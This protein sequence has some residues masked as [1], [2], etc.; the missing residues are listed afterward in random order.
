MSRILTIVGARP[1]FIKAAAVSH[2]L[3]RQHDEQLVHTGQHYDDN[4]SA[5]F[6]RQLGIPEP[7]HHLEV[8]SGPHGR[9]TGRMMEEIEKLVLADRPDWML[10]YGDTNSTLAGALVAA[11]LDVKVAHVE[12]GLRSYNRQMPE[13]INRVLTDH[14]STLLFCP[15]NVAVQNL[16]AEGLTRG[17]HEVGDVM[18]DSLKLAAANAAKG[19]TVIQRLGLEAGGYALVTVHRAENTDI[20][21]RLHAIVD[22]IN[23]MPFPV[24]FPVHP[25]TRAALNAQGLEFRAHVHLL[26]PQGYVDMVA[27]L[28]GARVA[29][30]DSG[31]LQKEAYWLSTPCVTLRTETEW[32]ETVTNGWN[33]LA[34]P[35]VAN[36]VEMAVNATAPATRPEL[37]G[38]GGASE[39][40]AEIIGAAA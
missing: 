10:L 20:P 23:S 24:I 7:N 25:R 2:V 12:A 29:C 8:G 34:A 6:F 22:A 39:R 37:Y 30:T 27:L 36:I 21:E 11:K 17:V 18:A 16:A 40:I 9:Q 5:L 33:V 26:E 3:R 31:G 4:M 15:S 35:S 14:V 38:E 19:D 13:E 28:A 1:Q 32:V